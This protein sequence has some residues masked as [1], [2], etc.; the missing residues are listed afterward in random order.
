[1]R[2]IVGATGGNVG[3]LDG[4]VS[5]IGIGRMQIYRGSRGWDEDGCRAM[6]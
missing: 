4:S 1:M 6:W 3:L 5:W 2:Y